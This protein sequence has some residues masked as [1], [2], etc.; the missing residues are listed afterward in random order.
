M[1]VYVVKLQTNTTAL[2]A[3]ATRLSRAAAAPGSSPA[4]SA[5]DSLAMA[6]CS[7]SSIQASPP[8]SATNRTQDAHAFIL[9]AVVKRRSRQCRR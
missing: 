1:S 2:V 7:L 9:L 5:A 4:A 8:S 6:D 3:A